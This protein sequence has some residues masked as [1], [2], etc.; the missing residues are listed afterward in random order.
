MIWIIPTIAS[1]IL[2]AAVAL[3]DKYLLLRFLP[4]PSIYAFY[5][6][7]TGILV[8]LLVPFF[9]FPVISFVNISIAFVSG[10]VFIFGLLFL[11]SGLQK[12]EASRIVPLVGGGVP[13][14]TLLIS[15]AVFPEAGALTQMDII[16][17]LLLLAGT[18]LIS[19]E[20]GK[21]IPLASVGISLIASFSFAVS[22]VAIKQV[23]LTEMFW[24]GF[25]WRSVGVAGAAG[26][27]FLFFKEVR[28][29]MF[30]RLHRQRII[31]IGEKKN[32]AIFFMNYIAGLGA[33]VLQI[34]AIYLAPP[35]YIAFINALQGVQYI[36]LF[37]FAALAS[38]F[39]PGVFQE[40]PSPRGFLARLLAI[41][42]ITG[43]IAVL[44]FRL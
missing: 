2:F 17:F 8:F 39:F 14:F 4:R 26:I 21:H 44:A 6:G 19:Y 38:L 11:Y 1:Y 28:N 30:G 13:L 41:V 3:G 16:A 35:L 33:G 18:M 5:V 25:L 24:A 12:F 40:M 23:Y 20:R 27:L 37:L 22:F 10:G 34:F 9:G 7:L 32:L 42:C 36:F 15:M 29:D 43:G 31:A